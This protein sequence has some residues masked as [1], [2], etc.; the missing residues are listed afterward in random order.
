MTARLTCTIDGETYASECESNSGTN[1]SG[2]GSV[3]RAVLRYLRTA[4]GGFSGSVFA[5]DGQCQEHGEP[6]GVTI[7][8][9]V[10]AV[11]GGSTPAR[12]RM[13]QRAARQLESRGLADC[14]HGVVGELPRQLTD[15]RGGHH[16]SARPVPGLYV[17]ARWDCPHVRE[18][19]AS[20][21]ESRPA[22]SLAELAANLAAMVAAP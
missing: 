14:W 13:A 19:R 15:Y 4:P 5:P 20:Q 16:M 8:A 12:L 2:L 11:Y 10:T 22:A 18:W 3:Q 7:G 17:A 6:I 1:E 9:I 21:A